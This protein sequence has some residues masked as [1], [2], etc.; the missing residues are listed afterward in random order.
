VVD[1]VTDGDVANIVIR[2]VRSLMARYSKMALAAVVVLVWFCIVETTYSQTV[3]YAYGN[4][5]AIDGGR[6]TP[7]EFKRTIDAAMQR[8]RKVSGLK[9]RRW[10]P[11]APNPSFYFAT[12]ANIGGVPGSLGRQQGNLLLISSTRRFYSEEGEHPGLPNYFYTQRLQRTAMH[13]LGHWLGW[14]H[15]TPRDYL[16]NTFNGD[17]PWLHPSEVRRLRNR[18]GH[19][20]SKYRPHDR[21]LRENM[22]WASWMRIF[23]SYDN[24]ALYRR[25]RANAT[26]QQQH[27]Y[28]HRQVL[29][30]LAY[31]D[32][33]LYPLRNANRANVVAAT[34][35]WRWDPWVKDNGF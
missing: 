13:E 33:V 34:N 4:V 19:P 11:G 15:V 7:A 18:Y 2:Q 14:G 17:Y 29:E 6:I 16:M 5:T 30:E 23:E 28:W 12:R 3:Y 8:M 1:V 22:L 10:H 31:L 20:T 26:T 32:N 9:L 25:N 21:Q 24:L 27:N 35:R